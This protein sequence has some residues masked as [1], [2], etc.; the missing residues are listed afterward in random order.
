MSS[1]VARLMLWMLGAGFLA[2]LIAGASGFAVGYLS[3][4][5]PE[6]ADRI[7]AFGVIGLGV[8]GVGLAVAGIW[9]SVLWMRSIDEAA[10]EAHKSAWFWGGSGALLIA[11]PLWMIATLP[12]TASW[13]LPDW[14]YG[15]TDPVAHAALGAGGLMALMLTGY[16]VAWAIWWLQ[17]R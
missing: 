5:R 13:S 2:G 14:F 4:D 6:L 1:K 7:A 15:R 3:I 9:T 11:L 8:I 12:T 16:G 10:R 17:R